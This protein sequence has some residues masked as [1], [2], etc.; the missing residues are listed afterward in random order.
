[1]E[2]LS[3]QKR[4][5]QV[6]L[7]FTGCNYFFA[8]WSQLNEIV[9]RT[10]KNKPTICYILPPNGT[11]RVERGSTCFTDKPNTLVAFL[12]HTDMDFDGEENDEVIE[13]MKRLA[14]MFI[15]ALNDSGLFNM[16]DEENIEYQVPYDTTDDNLT[17][18]LVTLPIEEK[19]NV[20]CQMPDDFGYVE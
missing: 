10:Q 4:I 17:G 7:K 5:K 15:K 11:I 20:M 18:V 9:D 6:A 8:N 13:K 3:V 16:I 19:W 2:H 1:M 14:M 12:C